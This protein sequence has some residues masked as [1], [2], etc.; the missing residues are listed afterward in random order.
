[1]RKREKEALLIAFFREK[2]KYERLGEFIIHL[3]RDDPSAPK[4]H[5]HTI[6]YRLKDEV[7]LIEKIDKENKSNS[8]NTAA[9]TARNF[10]EHIGDLLGIRL[11]C[12]RLADIN[13]IEAYLETLVQEKILEFVKEP[14]QKRSFILP[15]DPGEAIR[16]S[17]DLMY[18]GYSSIHYQITLGDSSGAPDELKTLQ[19]EFQLRT[20][21]EE[22]WGEID[23]KYRYAY[24]RS[25]ADLPEYIHSGFYNLSAYLQAAAMQAEYLCRQVQAYGQAQIAKGLP[26]SI[27]KSKSRAL[28]PA[29]IADRG[30]ELFAQAE[31]NGDLYRDREDT[32]KVL[33]KILGF[34]PTERTLLY[35]LKRFREF[36]YTDLHKTHIQNLV[37][38]NLLE[39]FKTVFIEI[40]GFKAF[41][42][43]TRRNV[44][45][46]NAINFVLFH[47]TQGA[48]VA[49]EGLRSVLKNRKERAERQ[50]VSR[51]EQLE[52]THIVS[53]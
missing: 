31:K 53:K 7:S 10:Q 45:A 44:D 13:I 34:R 17:P 30:P 8:G 40:L 25:G 16:D 35:I 41:S 22:A 21:L 48:R 11:V 3:I 51:S 49:L 28:G 26:K 9:V 14:L 27:L 5:F 43:T 33:E 39:E 4:N 32:E 38:K 42:D 23:H 29:G 47:E 19:A 6:F 36:G 18:S 50:K 1:M 37:N 24:C 20:I 52:N 2:I 46:I 12:L 15:V